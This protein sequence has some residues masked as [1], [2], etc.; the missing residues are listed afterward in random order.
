V[1]AVDSFRATMFERGGVAFALVGLSSGHP[2]SGAG[3]SSGHP[4][5]GAVAVWGGGPENGFHAAMCTLHS[6]SLALI[7]GSLARELGTWNFELAH[8][9]LQ[10]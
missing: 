10:L 2:P 6:R 5:S 1:D 7:T 3:S 8:H 9:T 4:P